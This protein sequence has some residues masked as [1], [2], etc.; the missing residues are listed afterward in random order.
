[1]EKQNFEELYKKLEEE[2][3]ETTLKDL[4][5][6]QKRRAIILVSET[7]DIVKV[8]THIA[9]DDKTI[10][11]SWLEKN[12]VQNIENHEFEKLKSMDN[13]MVSFIIIQPFVLIQLYSTKH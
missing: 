10:I 12:L 11:Q 7:L 8:G 6:H 3:S 5:I 4:E 9:L 1:M 2:K 13:K